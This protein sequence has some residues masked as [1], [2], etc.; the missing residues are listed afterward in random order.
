MTKQTIHICED[1]EYYQ[2]PFNDY[3]DRGM[4]ECM[5]CND[6]FCDECQKDHSVLCCFG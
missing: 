4:N 2:E 5:S 3:P 6:W 1:C